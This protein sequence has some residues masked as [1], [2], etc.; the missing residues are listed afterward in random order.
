MRRSVREA[1]VHQEMTGAAV[2]IALLNAAYF[3]ANGPVAG[4]SGEQPRR[5]GHQNQ[6][7]PHLPNVS[8][9]RLA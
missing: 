1:F 2:F 8:S 7:A 6:P 3:V 5:R 9:W 4:P